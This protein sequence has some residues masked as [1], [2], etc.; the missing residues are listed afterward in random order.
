M[1]FRIAILFLS[2]LFVFLASAAHFSIQE[3]ANFSKLTLTQVVQIELINLE[4]NLVHDLAYCRSGENLATR[5]LSKVEKFKKEYPVQFKSDEKQV[6]KFVKKIE[7]YER[8]V[9]QC[10]ILSSVG[11]NL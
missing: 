4:R 6:K 2:S 10:R 11:M 9:N 5:T 7:D 3:K 1:R 8:Q